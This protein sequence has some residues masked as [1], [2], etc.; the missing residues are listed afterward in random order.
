M[1]A[2]PLVPEPLPALALC[3]VL[4]AVA[5]AVTLPLYRSIPAGWHLIDEGGPVQTL[6][7]VLW[8]AAALG[9]VLAAIRTRRHRLDWLAAAFLMAFLAAR[10]LDAQKAFTDW[11]LAHIPNYF[12][13]GIPLGQRLLALFLYRLPPP[14]AFV[15]LLGRWG[16]AWIAGL[17]RRRGWALGIAA[18]FALGAACAFMDK[19]P[20]LIGLP[21]QRRWIT[22]TIEE[23]L[24]LAF[25][26]YGFLLLAWGWRFVRAGRTQDR[27]VDAPAPE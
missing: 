20:H 8:A 23:F 27:P 11:N 17:R 7:W 21:D 12:D 10:E 2:L 6:S 25:A 9:N 22:N 26:L 4:Y 1:R 14:L 5:C 3:L 18:L 24:E 15:W 19:L 16:G 13:S